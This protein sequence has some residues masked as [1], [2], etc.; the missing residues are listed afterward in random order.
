MK[1]IKLLALALTVLATSC[2]HFE[3]PVTKQEA[4]VFSESIVKSLAKKD[5]KIYNEAIDADLLA[6]RITDQD[7]HQSASYWKG[8]KQGVNSS[9]NFGTLILGNLGEKGSYT[10]VKQYEKADK[11]HLV[12]R[13]A[14]ESGLNYHDVE[15]AHKD[16]KVKIADIFIYTTGELFSETLKLMFDQSKEK[17]N[18]HYLNKLPQIS[19][20][21]QRGQYQQAKNII[22]Q[23]PTNLQ[24]LKTVQ[25]SYIVTCSHISDSAHQDAIEK[26]GHDF[27]NDPSLDLMLIDGFLLKKK[28]DEALA[29]VNRLDKRINTDP[30][31]DFYR[32]MFYNLMDKKAEAQQSLERLYKNLPDF[33]Q[34]AIELCT[35]YL[36]KNEY[37]KAV[38][39]INKVKQNRDFD[40]AHLENLYLLY[41]KLKSLM[42]K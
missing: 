39:I 40:E 23:L 29:C 36:D 25:I 42:G 12:F 13:L 9:I 20:L 38:G 37:E 4:A 26:Y 18:Y 3:K 34:G 15:L 1:Y 2:K 33:S 17:D 28:Y 6:D 8:L 7:R 19:N 10:L 14:A 21:I 5:A 30:Y 31:L 24:T 16:G 11:Q 41:P 35:Y 32:G 22:D 27:P